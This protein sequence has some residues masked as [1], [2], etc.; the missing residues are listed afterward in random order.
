MKRFL[1]TLLA[2]AMAVLAVA[3]QPQPP[4]IPV[5]SYRCEVRSDA[6]RLGLGAPI[7][8][9]YPDAAVDKTAAAALAQDLGLT[10]LADE[11]AGTVYVVNPVGAKYNHAADF[12]QYKALL[13]ELRAIYNL[14]VIGIGNGATFVNTCIAGNAGEVA[15]IVTLGGKPGKAV[16][17]APEVPAYIG[18]AN[19]AKVAAAYKTQNAAATD[20]LVQVVVNPDKN[21]SLKDLMADAWDRLMSR[22]YRYSNYMHTWYT[23]AEF[24]QYGPYELEPYIMPEQLG[25]VRNVVRK[26]L[27]GSGEFLWYEY[28]PRNLLNAP[29]KSVPLMV[30]LHGHGN[31]PRTQAEAAGF[32]ELAPSE[33]F[34]V[35]ELE[36]EGNG[37]PVMGLDGIEQVVYELLNKYPQLDPARVY[38]EGLSAGGATSNCLG[39]RKSFLFA[40]VGAHSAGMLPFIHLGA[41][42][43]SLMNEATQKAG[44][45]E[46][47]YFSV[48]GT[49]DL[50][51]WFS[52]REPDPSQN[53]LFLGWKTYAT[54][55]GIDFP[56]SPDF[57]KDATFGVELRDRETIVTDKNGIT[58]DTGRLYKGNKPLVQ[59]VAINGYGHWDF[60]PDA[61]LMWDFFK[62]FSRDPKTKKLVYSE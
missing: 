43:E 29:A 47:P 19:A 49:Q 20:P 1:T 54:M 53:N 42:R 62:H 52:D 51:I 34:I 37:N 50:G 7:F 40:G 10:A 12:E 26:D 32:V 61:K 16:K 60:K 36:W 8:V 22:N 45:V 56:E 9:V 21:A 38:A 11:F 46:M 33:G 27:M 25:I 6:G 2:A 31:D 41:S 5:Y 14:K 55:N 35:A 44:A 48:T 57:S 58:M 3:Q 24:G 15:G 17:G 13:K 4:Q 23:G 28:I 59:L 39:I 18:G 30:L